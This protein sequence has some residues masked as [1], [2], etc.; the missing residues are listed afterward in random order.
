[1]SKQNFPENIGWYFAGFV[2]GEGSFNI[3][4]R[5]NL[6]TKLNGNQFYLL[7]FHKENEKY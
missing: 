2:D 7:M 5:K 1:M 6:T 3:S 4:L